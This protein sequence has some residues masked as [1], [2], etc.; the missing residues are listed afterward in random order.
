MTW[1]RRW[2]LALLMGLPPIG[3]AQ[4]DSLSLNPEAWS[5]RYSQGCHRTH[6]WQMWDG[7]SLSRAA[8]SADQTRLSAFDM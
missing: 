8:P 2:L 7:P 4:A 1:V 3:P 5:V 6:L